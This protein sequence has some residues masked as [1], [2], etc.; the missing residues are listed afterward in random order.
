MAVSLK[1]Y[2]RRQLL[3]CCVL[4][5]LGDDV[6]HITEVSTVAYSRLGQE[7]IDQ[8]LPNVISPADNEAGGS[9]HQYLLM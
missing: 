5:Y 7:F 1:V 9:S 8:F 4:F 3:L 2:N 6:S